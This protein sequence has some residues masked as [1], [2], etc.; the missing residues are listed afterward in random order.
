M[1]ALYGGTCDSMAVLRRIARPLL[2]A[3]F[4]TDGVRTLRATPSSGAGA[5]SPS[6]SVG[7]VKLDPEQLARVTGAV[8]VGAGALLALGRFPRLAS[9]AL[10][11]SLVPATLT[12]QAWWKEEDP[13]L[14]KDRRDRFLHSVGLFGGLLIAAADTHGK[15]SAAYRTRHAASRGRK[16]A[17]GATSKGRKEVQGATSK[18]RKQVQGATSKVN[19]RVHAAA[20]TVGSNLSGAVDSAGRAGHSAADTVRKSLPGR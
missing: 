18:G 1:S 15:P 16:K 9:L 3:P 17:Q 6:L 10:A 19:S 11:A 20:D 4:V 12:D 13:E 8:Q 2:A 7:S 5:E 14:R